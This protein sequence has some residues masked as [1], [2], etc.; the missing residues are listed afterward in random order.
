[1]QKKTAHVSAIFLDHELLLEKLEKLIAVPLVRLVVEV[2][3]AYL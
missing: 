3:N 2:S 1:M